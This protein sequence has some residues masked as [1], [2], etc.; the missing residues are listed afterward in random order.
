MELCC[1]YW[2]LL[3]PGT[4]SGVDNQRLEY[5]ANRICGKILFD[6]YYTDQHIHT[7]D[8]PGTVRQLKIRSC[9]LDPHYV[10]R[11]FYGH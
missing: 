6:Q 11:V 1:P 8:A 7:L 10:R 9:F 5:R 3:P 2:Q 4:R